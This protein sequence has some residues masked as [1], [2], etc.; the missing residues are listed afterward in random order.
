MKYILNTIIDI[1]NRDPEEEKKRWLDGYQNLITKTH[2]DSEGSVCLHTLCN[3]CGGTGQ[4]QDGSC[5]VHYL[6]CP[7]NKCTPR[8]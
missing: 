3:E 6:S 2:I 8:F 5:C 4:K 1:I 7:C